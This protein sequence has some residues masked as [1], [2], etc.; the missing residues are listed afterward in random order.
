MNGA[1][2]YPCV[3][4]LTLI[5]IA[6]T[7]PASG[8]LSIIHASHA[9][10]ETRKPV[11]PGRATPDGTTRATV[12]A[13]KARAAPMPPNQAQEV[14]E[15]VRSGQMEPPIAQGDISERLNHLEGG[16]GTVS[17]E[18]AARRSSR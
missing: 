2:A 9:S 18:T 11:T 16:S 13:G 1:K 6:E 12:P 8:S 4:V 14:E 5:G 7:M 17:D 10:S 15:R 3:I